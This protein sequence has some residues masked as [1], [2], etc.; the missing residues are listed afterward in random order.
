M[1]LLMRLKRTP[2]TLDIHLSQEPDVVQGSVKSPLSGYQHLN[3]F[4]LQQHL[5]ACGVVIR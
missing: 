4:F 3:G 5:A 1:F 2:L